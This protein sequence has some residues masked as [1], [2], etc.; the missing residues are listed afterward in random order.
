VT[1]A[2]QA[3]F[4]TFGSWLEDAFDFTPTALSVVVIGLGFTE[5][6]ASLTSARRTDAWGKERSTAAG[7]ALMVVASVA[8]AIWHGHVWIALPLCII[9]IAVFEFAIVSAI[10]LSTAAI[11][12]SPARG[13]ALMMGAG[14]I[15]RAA[16]SIPAT[17]LYE[18]RG[19][20]WPALLCAA[21]GTGT[22]VSMIALPRKLPSVHTKPPLTDD[23]V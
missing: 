19:M 13:M 16:A 15:G 6:A 14:T 20:A 5:L 1:A 10:P 23:L 9:A 4:L 2:I 8:L 22:V 21:L 12:G 18:S 17:R 11:V 7:A 3:L